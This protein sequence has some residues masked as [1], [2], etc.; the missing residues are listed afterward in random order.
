MRHNLEMIVWQIAKND[1]LV[2]D[3]QKTQMRKSYNLMM[4]RDIRQNYC[5]EQT[6][7]VLTQCGIRY[8]PLKRAVLKDDYP[9]PH[10]RS[11]ADIDFYIQPE[12][13]QKIRAAVESIEGKL[14]GTESGDEQ[15][16]FWDKEGVEF[17]GRLLYRKKSGIENYPDWSFV[18]EDRNRLAE[19]GC[20]LNLIGHAVH[21]L[22]GS[23]PGIWY[24]FDL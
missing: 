19:E 24:I 6:E 16:L 9:Q 3:E 15:F 14:K 5:L 12:N 2:P 11:V 13:R 10:L 8:A 17:H 1:E 22:A 21:D 23:G 4:A 18:D 7:T 20:A